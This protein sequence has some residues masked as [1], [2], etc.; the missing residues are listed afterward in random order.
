MRAGR[1]RRG[2]MAGHGL[3]QSLGRSDAAEDLDGHD[4][5]FDHEFGLEKGERS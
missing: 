3:E 1:L 2:R 5:G 4:D